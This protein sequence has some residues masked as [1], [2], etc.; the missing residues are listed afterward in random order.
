MVPGASSLSV[1][2]TQPWALD[3]VVSSQ[4]GVVLTLSHPKIVGPAF[5]GQPASLLKA[6]SLFL[7]SPPVAMAS[8]DF[9]L[10]KL[11]M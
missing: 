10:G 9:T 1:L 8:S 4:W 2:A 11:E 6:A 7:T 3:P 5:I